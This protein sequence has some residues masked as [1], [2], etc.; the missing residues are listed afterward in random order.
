LSGFRNIFRLSPELQVWADRKALMILSPSCF[1]QDSL[2]TL[3]PSLSPEQ[4]FKEVYSAERGESSGNSG[5]LWAI[6]LSI[7]KPKFPAQ[8]S[9]SVNT[10]SPERAG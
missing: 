5:Y 2:M 8:S 6:K 9:L 3:S 7:Q 1:Y 4:F 10:L